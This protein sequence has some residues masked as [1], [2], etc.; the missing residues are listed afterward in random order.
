MPKTNLALLEKIVPAGCLLFSSVL[1]TPVFGFKLSI[2]PALLIHMASYFILGIFFE[3]PELTLNARCLLKARNLEKLTKD[4]PYLKK[5]FAA[6][7]VLTHY[8]GPS[9][10][11]L[12]VM[13]GL[14]LI[15]LGG[16]SLTKGWLFW[17]LAAAII[18]LY[19]GMNQHNFYVKQLFD[20]LRGETFD[21]E[22]V[23]VLQ[24]SI[25]CPF[26]QVLI[27]SELP[28]YLFIYG[29]AYYK[30]GWFVNP[31][32]ALTAGLEKIFEPAFLG[33]LM[34]GAGAWLIPVIRQGMKRWSYVY[35]QKSRH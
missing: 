2:L 26:D 24:S 6:R 23:K 32:S 28:T 9:S 21:E 1:F 35:A 25:L 27:F 22:S 16:Y 13:S 14:Y 20:A 31:L 34:V 11:I 7:Y 8:V 15:H 4:L 10:G 33:L 18:G 3:L 19:K 12:A 5:V 29:A 17:V 30:P